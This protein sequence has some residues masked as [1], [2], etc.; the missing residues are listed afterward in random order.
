M[1]IGDPSSN[2]FCQHSV[3]RK[4]YRFQLRR[5]Q[6]QSVEETYRE[7]SLRLELVIEQVKGEPLG[8]SRVFRLGDLVEESGGLV[9]T[10]LAN[11][12]M[13]LDS[14]DGPA[15]PEGGDVQDP[16]LFP[17]GV[18]RE[19]FVDGHPEHFVVEELPRGLVKRLVRA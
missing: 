8:A 14:A 5:P 7:T 18:Y 1:R 3:L 13:L 17:N 4:N 15:A 9:N 12:D 2:N 16:A 6:I 19:D 11:V 10:I